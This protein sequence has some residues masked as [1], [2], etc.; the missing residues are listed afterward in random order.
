MVSYSLIFEFKLRYLN[1]NCYFLSFCFKT[2]FILI[3]LM[4]NIS[5]KFCPFTQCRSNVKRIEKKGRTIIPCTDLYTFTN[6]FL[7]IFNSSLDTAV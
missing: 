7:Y 2:K 5:D 6:M 3:K 1:A 4:R